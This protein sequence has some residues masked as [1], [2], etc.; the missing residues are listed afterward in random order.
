MYFNCGLLFLLVSVGVFTEKVKVSVYYETHCPCSVSFI[1]KQLYLNYFKLEDYLNVELI[2]YGNTKRISENG[3]MGFT[4][5]KDPTCRA[6]RIHACTSAQSN[7]TNATLHFLNCVIDGQYT[8]NEIA[9]CATNF[10]IP[11]DSIQ[12]CTSSNASIA[13]L[14]K[15]GNRTEKLLSAH[16]PAISFND[17][18]DDDVSQKARENFLEAVCLALKTNA[19][20]ICSSVNLNLTDNTI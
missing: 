13:L 4:C 2:P 8:K 19:P 9:I 18:Y 16:I 12:N 17:N 5:K 11:I 14:D 20:K 3:T 7:P 6:M 1:K 10:S 15:F